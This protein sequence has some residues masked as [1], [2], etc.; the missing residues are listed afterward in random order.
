MNGYASILQAIKNCDLEKA[1]SMLESNIREEAAHAAGNVKPLK[2][3]ST[4]MKHA[5]NTCASM[6]K[7]H[8]ENGNYYFI[9]GHRIF[10]AESDLG[11]AHAEEYERFKDIARFFT[12]TEKNAED[13]LTFSKA[14]IQ[15]FIK[16]NYKEMYLKWAEYSQNGYYGK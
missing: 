9:D 1:I 7:A 14:E 5:N 13:S 10:K 8:V 3:I 2:I 11:F 4:M 15:A 6:Q 12:D 16:T